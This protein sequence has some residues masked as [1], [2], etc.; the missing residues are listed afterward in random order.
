MSGAHET[1]MDDE[2]RVVPFITLWQLMQFSLPSPFLG[3]SRALEIG[4]YPYS[5]SYGQYFPPVPGMSTHRPP[6]EAPT[7]VIATGRTA[8]SLPE[9]EASGDFTTITAISSTAIFARPPLFLFS[10]IFV[11]CRP[12]SPASQ[13]FTPPGELERRE[14]CVEAGHPARGPVFR[15]K[16]YAALPF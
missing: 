11:L 14:R 1:I 15:V 12:R 7:H 4:H 10:L 2:P 13:S 5:S 9:A 3:R 16:T 6:S 8:D